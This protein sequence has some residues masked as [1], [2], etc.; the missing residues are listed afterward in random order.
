[1]LRSINMRVLAGVALISLG[2]GGCQGQQLSCEG[3]IE[4]PESTTGIQAQYGSVTCVTQG[5]DKE[6]SDGGQ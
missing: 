4:D 3:T 1:M 2:A 6:T 5:L